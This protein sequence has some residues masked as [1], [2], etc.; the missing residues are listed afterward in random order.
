MPVGSWRDAE[1]SARLC[2]QRLLVCGAGRASRQPSSSPCGRAGVGRAGSPLAACVPVA[3]GGSWPRWSQHLSSGAVAA[4]SPG[5]ELPCWGVQQLPQGASTLTGVRRAARSQA[6]RRSGPCARVVRLPVCWEHVAPRRALGS[7]LPSARGAAD[8]SPLQ[9]WL[10]RRWRRRRACSP[11][12]RRLSRSSSCSRGS[13]TTS[14]RW[15]TST[16]AGPAGARTATLS[17][18]AAP[19]RSLCS[20]RLP[21]CFGAARDAPERAAAGSCC[22]S[23]VHRRGPARPPRHRQLSPAE[24]AAAAARWPCSPVAGLCLLHLMV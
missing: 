6:P 14:S 2:P 16:G 23:A 18:T 24:T 15:R 13:A 11:P 5:D 10:M 17:R 20:Q 22:R 1:V 4:P 21:Y 12:R 9:Q 19:R 3:R 7:R 8:P